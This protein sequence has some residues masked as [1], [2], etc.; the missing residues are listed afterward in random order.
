MKVG[1]L[2]LGLDLS[3]E[4]VQHVISVADYDKSGSIEY[5]EFMTT[6]GMGYQAVK[7][8]MHVCVCVRVRVCYAYIL[9][10]GEWHMTDCAIIKIFRPNNK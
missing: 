10:T 4:D 8:C 5:D 6:F 9:E 1:L 7:V 2:T 3:E